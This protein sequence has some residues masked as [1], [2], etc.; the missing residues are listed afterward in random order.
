MKI[1]II[2]VI[3]L[4]LIFNSCTQKKTIFYWGDY[5]NT[6]YEYKKDPND[7]NLAKHKE[8]MQDI[9]SKSK[10]KNINVPP[11]VYCEYGYI[12]AQEGMKSEAKIVKASLMKKS[13]GDR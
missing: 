8:A 12:L 11:G 7:E 2:T 4:C 1:S 3:F 6:L 5:S 13:T 9:I 10:E